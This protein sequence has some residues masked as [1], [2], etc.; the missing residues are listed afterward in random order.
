[1]SVDCLANDLGLTSTSLMSNLLEEQFLTGLD[2]NLFADQFLAQQVMYT[3]DYTFLNEKKAL[4]SPRD[5][6]RAYPEGAES[7]SRLAY[8]YN[9][10]E[11]LRVR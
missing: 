7:P 11:V 5:A 9:Q 1:M 3:S 4:L 10:R 6:Q 2:I 8:G